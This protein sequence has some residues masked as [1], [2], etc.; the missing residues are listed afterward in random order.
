MKILLLNPPD[1]HVAKTTS[2]W[3]ISASD[4][5]I[6]PPIGLTYLGG[7][8]R[9]KTDHEVKIYDSILEG[10][11][12]EDIVKVLNDYKPDFVGMTAYTPT[13]FD[14]LETAKTI[15]RCDP[16]IHV[17]IG[18]A[19]AFMFGRETMEH[20]V[21]DSIVLGEGESTI[22]NITNALENNIPLHKIEGLL[23][24]RNGEVI[25]TGEPGYHDKLDELPLPAFDMLPF[26]RYYS[27]IGTGKT[28]GTILTSRGCPYA[29]TFCCKPYRTYRMR[30]IERILEEMKLYIDLGVR[31]F[32]FFDDLFNIN[33][34]RVI[35]L[36]QAILDKGW[37]VDWSFRGRVDQV[38]EEMIKTAK[39]A[40][41]RQILF[42]V[43]TATNEGLKAINKNIKI[44]Q[45]Y[46][47]MRMCRRSGIATSTNW[48]IGF[49]HHTKKEDILGLID[50]AVKVDSDYAQFNILIPYHGTEIFNE[51]SSK[52]LFDSETWRKFVLDPKPNFEEPVWE[53]YMSR[54]ELSGLLS[55]CYRRFYFRPK[56][57]ARKLIDIRNVKHFKLH[58]KGALTLLGFGGYKREEKVRAC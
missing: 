38:T 3:D 29:C 24:R 57:I 21:F 12:Q 16:R 39:K 19:H 8:L 15:K 13:F 22:V 25:R 18:G 43:E 35:E 6:F 9:S 10:S 27:A 31:E 51:G 55:R 45:V 42:G 20:S 28:V 26:R 30:S 41:C 23:I 46:S 37:D 54:E 4:I 32:F 40:G 7:A 52:G 44:E 5:G 47:A 53:E 48:I 36:S 11:T 2:D 50:T 34:K 1:R 17:C 33:P 58:V 14:L 56:L 49:P